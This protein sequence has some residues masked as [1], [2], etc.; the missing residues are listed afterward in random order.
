MGSFFEDFLHPK[1]GNQQKSCQIH[2]RIRPKLP[3]R[4]KP[5]P[6]AAEKQDCA[7]HGPQR[8]KRPQFSVAPHQQEHERRS[9]HCCTVDPIQYVG[10]PG[11]PQAKGP[12]K[13]VKHCQR[14]PQQNGLEK[15]QQLQ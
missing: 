6:T 9:T 7:S 4:P 13:I 10:H 3:D 8:H 1:Y 12:Q 11:K 2:D 5:G 15:R 14:D